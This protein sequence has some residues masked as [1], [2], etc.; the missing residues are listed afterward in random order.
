MRW[1]VLPVRSGI[2]VG[3]LHSPA[4]AMPWRVIGLMPKSAGYGP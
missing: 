2:D 4:S 3:V 1:S